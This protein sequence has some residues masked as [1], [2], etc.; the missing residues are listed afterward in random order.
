M[1]WSLR[2][3]SKTVYWL[4]TALF[5]VFSLPLRA[6]FRKSFEFAGESADR[7]Y[8]VLVFPE[9]ARTQDGRLAAFRNGIG[10]LA[11]GLRLPVVPLRIDGLWEIK[12]TGRRGSAPWGT[13]T[14]RIGA[15]VKI[16]TAAEAEEVTRELERR[17]REL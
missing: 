7:G 13:I 5:N 15:L 11:N 17:V 4:M 3:V 14:I 12:R 16:D 1:N 9:G 10:I 8:S 6:G 2:P